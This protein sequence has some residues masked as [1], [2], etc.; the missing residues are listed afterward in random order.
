MP[1]PNQKKMLIINSTKVINKIIKNLY[2]FLFSKKYRTIEDFI[3]LYFNVQNKYR[4]IL[5]LSKIYGKYYYKHN[6]YN[7]EHH[8]SK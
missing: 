7:M 3:N 6:S 4:I 5:F 2:Q 1:I 8:E